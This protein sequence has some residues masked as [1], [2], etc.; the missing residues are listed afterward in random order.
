MMR[1][2]GITLLV[3]ITVFATVVLFQREQ[4]SIKYDGRFEIDQAL[5]FG[6]IDGDSFN[7]VKVDRPGQVFLVDAYLGC[8]SWSR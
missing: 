6:I 1:E 2:L 3:V 8:C 7:M 5:V 4:N